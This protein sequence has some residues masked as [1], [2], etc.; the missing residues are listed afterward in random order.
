M[1]REVAEA[2]KEIG[3]VPAYTTLWKQADLNLTDVPTREC[4]AFEQSKN[5]FGEVD[6]SYG[7]V[8]EY[9]VGGGG[10]AW[11]R[12]QCQ[13]NGQSYKLPQKEWQLLPVKHTGYGELP[14]CC[15]TEGHS[16]KKGGDQHAPEEVPHHEDVQAPPILQQIPVQESGHP[17]WLRKDVCKG[18]SRE[19]EGR[20]YLCPRCC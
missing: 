9:R 14:I 20:Y 5:V 2:I 1:K 8:K 16:I 19:G 12:T 11:V 6:P 7:K 15:C 4:L 10:V 13:T 18:A 3:K 17:L